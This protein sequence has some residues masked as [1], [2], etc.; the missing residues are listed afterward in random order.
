MGTE[1]SSTESAPNNISRRRVVAGAAWTVPAVMVASAAPAVAS[2]LPPVYPDLKNASAC[3]LPGSSWPDSYGCWDQGYVLFVEFVNTFDYPVSVTVTGISV[4]GVP[5]MQLVGT[6]LT[7]ACSTTV[8]CFDI[9]A[10]GSTQVA[11][12][13]NSSTNSASNVDVTVAFSWHDQPSCGGNASPA[14]VTGPIDGGA[15]WP[16]G[17][18]SCAQQNKL[19]TTCTVPPTAPCP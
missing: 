10:K 6:T 3:K 8:S 2:S 15:S 7:S 13:G 11:I 12:F 1:S 18:G 9:A 17:G 19:P 16:Q 14:T 4:T 5:D